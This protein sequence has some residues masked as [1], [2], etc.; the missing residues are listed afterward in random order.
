LGSV[1]LKASSWSAS[2][3]LDESIW[4]LLAGF[5]GA[6]ADLRHQDGTKSVRFGVRTPENRSKIGMKSV[7]STEFGPVLGLGIRY[8][9]SYQLNQADVQ[10]AAQSY[11]KS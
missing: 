4:P 3:Q 10:K 8:S 6:R 5:L 2:E 11:E 9:S 1:N 7:W